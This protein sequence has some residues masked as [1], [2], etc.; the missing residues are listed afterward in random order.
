M[1]GISKRRK[2]L[3]CLIILNFINIAL[4][5]SSN[6]NE[7][8]GYESSK[9]DQVTY[10]IAIKL[11]REFSDD[12]VSDLFATSYD[13]IKVARVTELDKENRLFHFRIISPSDE[14][15][16]NELIER[17][18]RIKRHV[19]NK[20]DLMRQDDRVD[21]VYPLK[22]L[23]REKRKSILLDDLND[24]LINYD[25]Q[26]LRY[27]DKIDVS[28]TE[29][30]ELEELY[31]DLMNEME[32]DKRKKNLLDIEK[33]IKKNEKLDSIKLHVPDEINFN[34]HN[35]K[36]QWY[37]INEGQLNIPPMH[38]LNVKNAWL[39]G[40]TGKNVTIVVIDDGLDHEHPD[41]A[42]KYVIKK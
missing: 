26:E 31:Q 32:Q 8:S 40:Y 1:K 18:K 28:N 16:A 24:D 19:E 11:K 10:D 36:Q 34:D 3:N 23:K 15:D 17:P 4:A 6:F 21:F 29:L 38:D 39:S 33:S 9:N 35:F 42:G 41:F 2:F 22:Y 14:L 7:F 13:L 37:L 27:V 5:N 25:K 20:I 30:K 12:L